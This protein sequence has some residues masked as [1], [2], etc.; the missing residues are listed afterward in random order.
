MIVIIYKNKYIN[1]I[2]NTHDYQLCDMGGTELVPVWEWI[3]N[4]CGPNLFPFEATPSLTECIPPG[5][6]VYR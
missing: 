1:E 2:I 5:G 6:Q 3:Y 4:P